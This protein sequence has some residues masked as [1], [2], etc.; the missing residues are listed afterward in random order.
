MCKSIAEELGVVPLRKFES[1]E[2]TEEDFIPL[3]QA[4]EQ[5]IITPEEAERWVASTE[6]YD[7]AL[8][9]LLKSDILEY[10]LE[11]AKEKAK[12]LSVRL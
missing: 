2:A 10:K 3:E 5:G 11:Q 7:K 1:G 6:A 8:D 4:I 9:S 12:R